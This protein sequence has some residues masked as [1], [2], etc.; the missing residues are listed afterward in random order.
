VFSVFGLSDVIRCWINLVFDI[1]LGI[2]LR[3]CTRKGKIRRIKLFTKAASQTA[4]VPYYSLVSDN[5]LFRITALCNR[6]RIDYINI[7]DNNCI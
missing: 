2:I 4:I 3:L 6:N 7:S 5:T 1:T